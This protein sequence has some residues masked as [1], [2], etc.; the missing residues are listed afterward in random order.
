MNMLNASINSNSI[1]LGNAGSIPIIQK[2][3]FANNLDITLGIRP[4]HMEISKN[5]AGIK[6]KV[7]VIEPNGADSLLY[8]NIDDEK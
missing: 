7:D 6:F 2:T 4:S 5:G 8:G 3:S 1:N